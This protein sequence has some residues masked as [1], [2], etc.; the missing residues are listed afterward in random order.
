MCIDMQAFIPLLKQKADKCI[1]YGR[2]T[3]MKAFCICLSLSGEEEIS[4]IK[5]ETI[6]YAESEW[7]SLKGVQRIRSRFGTLLTG[8]E[9]IC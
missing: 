1:I 7:L 8:T 9:E 3:F 2:E 6:P 4:R 5:L